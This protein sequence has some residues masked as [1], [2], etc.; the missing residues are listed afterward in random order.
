LTQAFDDRRGKVDAAGREPT[1]SE[2]VQIEQQQQSVDLR[3]EAVFSGLKID[4][5]G[6][7]FWDACRAPL[8]TPEDEHILAMAIYRGRE[9]EMVIESRQYKMADLGEWER[10]ADEGREAV[11][12]LVRANTRLVVSWAKKY[13]GRGLEFLDLIQE[14]N[15]GLVK[16]VQRFDPHRG[17]KFSTY[18]VWWIRQAI[19][20]GLANKGRLIRIPANQNRTLGRMTGIEVEW[21][22][23]HG[24]LPTDEELA[25][26]LGV[27]VVQV[28][29][30]RRAMMLQVSLDEPVGQYGDRDGHVVG[31]FLA[32]TRVV[33][34]Q[35]A[36]ERVDVK[37]RMIAALEESKLTAR[38]KR[39]LLLRY[40]FVDGEEK[41]LKQIGDLFRL[42]RERVRQL[43]KEALR[44]LK[45]NEELKKLFDGAKLD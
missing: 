4:D 20:R 33:G 5:L 23:N 29:N 42:S 8:L 34:P 38:E 40:G 36:M 22:N 3:L 43:E 13:R 11:D 27:R 41:T 6:L 9:A 39:I 7:Y 10:L 15:E 32:D 2:L 24:R 14:G 25:A 1:A 16:A 28:R 21:L 30:L 12:K 18:A 26:E 19:G 31:D 45:Q 17:T 37:E 35:I 44:K